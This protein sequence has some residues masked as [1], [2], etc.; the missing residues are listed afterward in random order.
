MKPMKLT[1]LMVMLLVGF[2]AAAQ[3][4]FFDDVYFSS[5][6]KDKKEKTEEKVIQPKED[7]ERTTMTSTYNTSKRKSAVSDEE[8]DVD[9]YNRRYTSVDVEEPYDEDSDG[10]VLAEYNDDMD[11][12][13][14]VA[15]DSKKERRSDTEYTER[16]IRYHSPSKI[17]I[18]G[19]DQVD[20]YLSDGYYAYGYDTDYSNGSTNVSV[21]V[22]I[23]NGWGGYYDPWYSMVAGTAVGMILGFTARPAIG[24]TVHP[25]VS[26]GVG[27]VSMPATGARL[28]AGVRVIGDL[29]IGVAATGVAIGDIITIIINRIIIG[30]RQEDVLPMQ[31]II[32]EV[33]GEAVVRPIVPVRVIAITDP[34][35]R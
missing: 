35:L 21:N 10:E 28:G 24:A 22:N 13:K 19:A 16:I 8:R 7:A 11:N 17:T 1:S 26:A 32:E 14:T 18:A 5:S 20:L 33:V 15:S 23:G 34:L 31:A 12:E 30:M 29:V 27:V 3:E 25:S 9:E 4:E 6:K 2:S